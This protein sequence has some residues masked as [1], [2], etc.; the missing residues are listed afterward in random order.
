M[1]ITTEKQAEKS[2]KKIVHQKTISGDDKA[3]YLEDDSK[4]NVSSETIWM[5]E[6]SIPATV[7]TVG[8]GGGAL[9]SG[10]IFDAAGL[11]HLDGSYDGIPIVQYFED[12]AMPL[13]L[14]TT[15]SFQLTGSEQQIL[16]FAFAEGI[17]APVVKDQSDNAVPFGLNS[18]ELD[19]ESGTI[20]F[21]DGTP[22]G[23]TSLKLT[24][25]KYVGEM[26]SEQAVPVSTLTTKTYK[27]AA[28]NLVTDVTKKDNDGDTT[29]DTFVIAHNLNATTLLAR[30]REIAVPTELISAE[31]LPNHVVG[32][33][34]FTSDYWFA[35]TFV[36]ASNIST[37]FEAYIGLSSIT[38]TPDYDL[39]LSIYSVAAGL[40]NALIGTSTNSINASAMSGGVYTAAFNFT[41]IPLS[42]GTEYALVIKSSNI[43][44]QDGSNFIVLEEQN[45][46]YAPGRNSFSSDSGSNWQDVSG[47]STADYRIKISTMSG[48]TGNIEVLPHEIRFIDAN[49]TEIE[50]RP[51]LPD[52]VD[53]FYVDLIKL[54]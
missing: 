53:E 38:G 17:Y 37:D 25:W 49:N 31:T 6:A 32:G 48:S 18:W 36:P 44:S 2:Y 3:F 46:Q 41:G 28:D 19:I 50:L 45:N 8:S 40:P 43:V 30:L 33:T 15:N 20:V 54:A 42:S 10:D 7:P 9:L 16:S 11:H 29:N 35:Q 47:L 22:A 24:Y 26:L 1:A 12:V 27:L 23:I 5:Q 34:S 39:T 51:S 21:F 4:I 14:G 52:D 13:V